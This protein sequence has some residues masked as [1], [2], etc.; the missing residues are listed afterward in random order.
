MDDKQKTEQLSKKF[1]SLKRH[2]AKVEYLHSK[3]P[4]T[5]FD[6]KKLSREKY[7]VRKI[8]KAISDIENLV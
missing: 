2:E 8:R 5:I 6:R 3:E 4:F 1:A 7:M